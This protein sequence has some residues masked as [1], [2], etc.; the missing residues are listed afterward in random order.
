MDKGEPERE[1]VH[2][3][4]GGEA[5][6]IELRREEKIRRT[7]RTPEAARDTRKFERVRGGATGTAGHADGGEPSL[8][9][10]HALCTG[11]SR[12]KSHAPAAP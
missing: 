3:E 12:R 11:R 2:K 1:R 4:G 5:E 6:R 8:N 9:Q 7:G 10:A